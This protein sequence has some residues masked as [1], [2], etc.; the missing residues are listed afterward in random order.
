MAGALALKQVSEF[1]NILIV[2]LSSG[3]ISKLKQMKYKITLAIAILLTTATMNA[4]SKKEKQVA[5]AVETLRKAMVDGDGAVLNNIA[6]D[7]LTY[8][9][10]SGKI[11][12]KQE[13]VE[14]LTSGKSDFVTIDLKDQTIEVSGDVAIVR[15]LLSAKTNDGGKPGE[16]TLKILTVWQKMKGGWKMLARQAVKAI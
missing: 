13:F 6:A 15:H 14:T 3:V 10:S 11:E 8:G 9:H 2:A 5:D 7:Q 4:Q 12:T 16:V 1:C